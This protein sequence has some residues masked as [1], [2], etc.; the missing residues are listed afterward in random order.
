MKLFVIIGTT[1]RKEHLLQELSDCSTNQEI[2]K[3]NQ[4]CA[5]RALKLKN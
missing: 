1:L 3:Q 5:T 2:N 4:Q